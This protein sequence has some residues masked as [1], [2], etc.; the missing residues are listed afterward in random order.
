MTHIRLALATA[1]AAFAAGLLALLPVAAGTTAAADTAPVATVVP[2][3]N[4]QWG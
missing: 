4:A 2:A 3:D 1:V